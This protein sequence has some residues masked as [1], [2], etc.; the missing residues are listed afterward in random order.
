MIME[1]I[2]E[3]RALQC[4]CGRKHCLLKDGKGEFFWCKGERITKDF[5]KS[6]QTKI[7]RTAKMVCHA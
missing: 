7:P 3:G 1:L 4:D 2:R 5:K 6:K